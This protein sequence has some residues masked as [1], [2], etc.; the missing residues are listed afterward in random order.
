MPY[1]LENALY[2]WREGQ[3]R[4]TEI[5]EPAR[6]DLDLAADRVVEELRRRLGSAFQLDELADLYG[7]GTDWATGLA[8]RHATSGEASVVVDAAFYRYAR[9][10]LNFG[11][12]RAI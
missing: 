3:R 5:D 4:I 11:G 7:A 1:A 6:A 10:A 9:E 8:G 2:Q 12:G